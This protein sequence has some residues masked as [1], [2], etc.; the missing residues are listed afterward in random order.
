MLKCQISFSI[1]FF[2]KIMDGET[3]MTSS[4]Q[5]KH[6]QTYHIQTHV[7]VYMLVTWVSSSF[8]FMKNLKERAYFIFKHSLRV[9]FITKQNL[10]VKLRDG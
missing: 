6:I 7:N 5:I 1:N 10:R 3:P 8:F 9:I 2:K 4:I